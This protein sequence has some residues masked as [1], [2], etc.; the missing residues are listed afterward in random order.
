MVMEVFKL[1]SKMLRKRILQLQ[2]KDVQDWF[3]KNVDRAPQLKGYNSYVAPH[4]H[5]EYQMDLF[6]INDAGE[7]YKIGLLMIDIF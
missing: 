1:L 4:A 6:F 5:F 3:N 7:A 2:L